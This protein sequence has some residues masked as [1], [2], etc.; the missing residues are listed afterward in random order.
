MLSNIFLKN[1]LLYFS[2]NILEQKENKS[3][4]KGN[5]I[6]TPK[7]IKVVPHQINLLNLKIIPYL[8]V[9]DNNVILK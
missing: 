8:F 1:F 9:V 2:T 3:W 7:I 6:D 5:H 4:S